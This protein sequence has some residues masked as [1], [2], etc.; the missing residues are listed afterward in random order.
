MKDR[1]ISS[2]HACFKHTSP[3]RIKISELV[4]VWHLFEY[5]HG[6]ENP[7]SEIVKLDVLCRNFFLQNS[8]FK[9]IRLVIKLSKS[10]NHDMSYTKKV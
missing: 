8:A 3:V 5:V 2:S 1:I 10:T 6:G 9:R 7:D 4:F